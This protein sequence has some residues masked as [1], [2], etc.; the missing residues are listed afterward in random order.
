MTPQEKARET[1]Q[2]NHEVQAR[3]WEEKR[4]ATKTARKAL[5]HV[6]EREDAAPA[7]ILRAAELLIQM[8]GI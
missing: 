6:L 1:R 8:G 5:L 4:E 7:E 3:L 2:K